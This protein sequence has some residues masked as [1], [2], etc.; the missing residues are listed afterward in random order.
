[1][2]TIKQINSLE[3]MAPSENH[4]AVYTDQSGLALALPRGT[5]MVIVEKLAKGDRATPIVLTDVAP[6][7]IKFKCGCG[8]EGC[9]RTVTFKAT[10]KGFHPQGDDGDAG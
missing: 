4:L 2:P 3:G 1:M 8:K 5:L 7:R 9:S 10:W 6:M